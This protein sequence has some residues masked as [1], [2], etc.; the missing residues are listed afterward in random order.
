MRQLKGL[1]LCDSQSLSA[2]D[3]LLDNTAVECLLRQCCEIVI[4]DVS[5]LG[6]CSVFLVPNCD[7]STNEE[8]QIS[9]S[10][11]YAWIQRCTNLF[12]DQDPRAMVQVWIV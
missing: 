1:V 2:P 12:P 11:V 5:R 7:T 8:L 4:C 10:K 3:Q 6:W 9:M